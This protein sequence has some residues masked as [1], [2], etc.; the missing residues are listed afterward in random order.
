MQVLQ[1]VTEYRESASLTPQLA[2]ALHEDADLVAS[3]C[4]TAPM[5]SGE[6]SV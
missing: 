3:A 5:P 6:A 4:R 2:K 1:C